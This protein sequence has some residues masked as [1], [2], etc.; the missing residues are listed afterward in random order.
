[1]AP[2]PPL[3]QLVR[4]ATRGDRLDLELASLGSDDPDEVA[5]LLSDFLSARL[6]PIRDALFYRRGTGI[7]AG[8]L[9]SDGRAVVAKVHRWRVSLARLTAVHAVQEH[10]ARAGLPAPGPLVAPE[11]F[12]AGIVTV[13]EMRQGEPA[14]G[15]DP[16]IRRGIAEGLCAFISA[17]A[18]VDRTDRS[19]ARGALRLR[20]ELVMA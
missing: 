1:M 16:T 9:L 19:R 18:P 17:T 2:V 15:H 14:D 4:E 7:V 10:L 12:R 20:Q 13:E 3:A 8:A 5:E 6:G 11:A